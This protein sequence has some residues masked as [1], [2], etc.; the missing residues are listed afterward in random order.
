MRPMPCD[1]VVFLLLLTLAGCD[2]PALQQGVPPPIVVDQSRA[3]I[4]LYEYG[5]VRVLR[6]Q[7]AALR[8]GAGADRIDASIET[9][10]QPE[11]EATR[12]LLLQLGLNPAKITVRSEP[13]NVVVLTRDAAT[14]ASCGTALHS[15]W[16]GD[17]SNS[18]TSLGACVQANNL[19]VMLDDPRDLVAPVRLEPADGAVSALAIQRW[20]QGDVK[21]P[22][23]TSLSSGGGGSAGGDGQAA[24][25]TAPQ[26][27]GAS[28][29]NPLLSNAPLSGAPGASAE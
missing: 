13:G 24:A 21:Q 10:S 9:L 1:R 11:T 23:R 3:V 2:D 15:D 29:A 14:V 7:V 18:I 28:P 12:D 8:A 26:S 19:A 22:P 4:P 20:E 17:V 27:A 5:A 16:L 25:G 6:S